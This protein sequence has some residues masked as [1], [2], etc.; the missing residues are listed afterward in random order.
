[1]KNNLIVE[2]V[3]KQEGEAKALRTFNYPFEALEEALANTVYH[4]SYQDDSPIEIR[5]FPTYIEMVSY[6]GP[7]PPLTREKLL[8]GENIVARKYRNRRIGDFLKELRLTEG[9]GTG[10]PKIRASMERNG[11]PE[12]IFDTD[13]DLRYFSVRMDIHPLWKGQDEGQDGSPQGQDEGQDKHEEALLILKFCLRPKKKREILSML[14]LTNKHETFVRRTR[15]LF[16]SGY[17]ELTVPD[18]T[19]SKNQQYRTTAAGEKF[20]KSES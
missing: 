5:V 9:R 1:M 8:S 2:M 20:L 19:R 16:A 13:E 10:I 3:S 14:N 7:L 15:Y 6:P 12:P 17:L 18:S 11:S 4:R